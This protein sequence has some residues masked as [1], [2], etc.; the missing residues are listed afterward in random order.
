MDDVQSADDEGCALPSPREG[1]GPLDAAR[2]E[3]ASEARSDALRE[4]PSEGSGSSQTSGQGSD[5]LILDAVV[6]YPMLVLVVA[7]TMLLLFA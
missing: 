3:P 5:A 2:S 1:V 7:I 6:F 4:K